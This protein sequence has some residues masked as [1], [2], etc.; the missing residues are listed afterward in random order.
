MRC[1]V[2]CGK[3]SAPGYLTEAELI[4]VM[5]RSG[6]GTDAS[7][8]THIENICKR[9]YV[10]VGSGRTM[11]PT[12][13]GVLLVQGYRAIDPDLVEPTVRSYV[14]RQLDTIASGKQDLGTVVSHVLAQFMAKFKYF[15]T[16][17]GEME[18]LFE[19]GTDRHFP[20]PQSSNHTNLISRCG[21]GLDG[22]TGSWANRAS[23][24]QMWKDRSVS[25][26]AAECTAPK[27]LQPPDG[28]SIPASTRRVAKSV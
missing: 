17:I 21:S 7:I 1:D 22:S 8:A 28:G 4:G 24:G 11:V 15:V 2:V 23:S 18:E 6:I 14:E 13:L 5:E 25:A 9:N 12:D 20:P 26:V 19:V 3:T 27:T 10:E 16:H